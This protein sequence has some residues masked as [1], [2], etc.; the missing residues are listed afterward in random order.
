MPSIHDQL[1]LEQ[2]SL[3]VIAKNALHDLPKCHSDKSHSL[4]LNLY[5]HFFQFS[6]PKNENFPSKRPIRTSRHLL[7]G[8]PTNVCPFNFPQKR[9]SLSVKNGLAYLNFLLKEECPF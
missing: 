4:I 9:T 7:I 5:L 1:N 3:K 8:F 2:A 6:I